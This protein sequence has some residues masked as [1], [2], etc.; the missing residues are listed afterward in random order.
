MYRVYVR[1]RV[2]I[3][4][5]NSYVSMYVYLHM[6]NHFVYLYNVTLYITAHPSL[7][8]D[9]PLARPRAEAGG[10]IYIYI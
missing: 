10:A 2:Y 1:I 8:G 6:S 7:L 9:A 3:S 4:Y 5:P